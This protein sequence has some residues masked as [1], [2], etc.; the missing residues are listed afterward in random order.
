[1]DNQKRWF[2]GTIV[3][4]GRIPP[5]LDSHL[6]VVPSPPNKLAEE[7][8]VEQFVEGLT[9][10]QRAFLR[11]YPYPQLFYVVSWGCAATAWLATILNRHPDIYCV[12]AANLHWHVLGEGEKLDG[13]R[14][15]RV[16]GSQGHSHVA[17][18]GVHGM[19]RHLVP[20]CRGMFGQQ[21]NSAVVVREPISRL[22]SMVALYDDFQECRVLDTGYV[23]GI[24]SRTGITVPPEDYRSRVFVHAANMLNAILDEGE[25]GKI[26]RCEDL[27]TNCQVLGKFVEEITRGKVSPDSAWLESAIHTKKVNVHAGQHARRELDDWQIDVVRKVVD[28]RAWELYE[29]LGYARPEF[30]AGKLTATRY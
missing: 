19:S 3:N 13:A 21:F 18:G 23:D 28:P 1:V 8:K 30:A 11:K 6:H 26:Y 5:V 2:G 27:T 7:K 24:L 20:E 22:R 15:L 12:H 14:Y 25:V 29:S 17:A 4:L 16:I 10:Y 9:D